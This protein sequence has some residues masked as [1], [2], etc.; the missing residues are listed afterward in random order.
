M[1]ININFSNGEVFEVKAEDIA[2]QVAFYFAKQ[3]DNH[4]NFKKVYLSEYNNV[5]DDADVLRDY[6]EN[7]MNWED[8]S[9]LA[10]RVDSDKKAPNYQEM[11][12][13]AEISTK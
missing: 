4:E 3:E 9:H 6:M 7:N 8:V 10:T 13:N 12:L 2:D 5:V 1:K 11:W